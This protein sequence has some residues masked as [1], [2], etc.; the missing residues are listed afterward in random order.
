MKSDKPAG[1]TLEHELFSAIAASTRSRV[2]RIICSG[3]DVN[4]S[5]SDADGETPLIRAV[6]HGECDLVQMLI[7][8]GA[9]VNLAQRAPKSWT[10]LMF[11]HWNA[12]ITG[13]L[14]SAGADV[15]ARTPAYELTLP[16][17]GRRYRAGGE[18]ALH[19]AAAANKADVVRIL[20]R[21]GADLKVRTA[22]GLAPLDLALALGRPTEA[23]AV[24]LEMGDHLTPQRLELIHSEAHSPDSDLWQFPWSEES[25]TRDQE[26]PAVQHLR[27]PENSHG[28]PASA[29]ARIG[30]QQREPR[31]P[32]CRSLIYSRRA[33]AC[34]TCGTPIPAQQQLTDELV[35]V[36]QEERRWARDLASVFGG[37][38]PARASRTANPRPASCSPRHLLEETSCAAVFK[39]R[40]R[41]SFWLYLI[42]YLA[43]AAVAAVLLASSQFASLIALAG[44]GLLC[45]RTWECATP[46]CPNCKQDIRRCTPV[47]CHVCGAALQSA[48]CARCSTDYSWTAL[49]FPRV[50]AGS[51]RRISYCPGCGVW[52]D[53]KV[54]RWRAGSL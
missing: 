19:L 45:Y 36:Q 1:N 9:D 30:T 18:T 50:N 39:Q 34:G 13:Q 47:Y 37:D 29:S 53:T 10:P 23:A 2:C 42:G 35:R 15:N 3:A 46:V 7:E 44:L 43:L 33:K 32:K 5:S 49:F 20:I 22:S 48:Y 26:V 12:S 54:T 38:G 14:L 17:T 11:A 8:A 41:P 6:S 21:A 52:L 28:S 51:F 27:E 31:C 16:A 24:L 4:C 25:D 40:G